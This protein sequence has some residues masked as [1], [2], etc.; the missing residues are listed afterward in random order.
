MEKFGILTYHRADNLGAVLQAYALQ[1]ALSVCSAESQIIDYCC[2]KVDGTEVQCGGL[3]ALVYKGYH[4]WKHIGFARFR[5]QFLN[6]SE[7]YTKKTVS[8]CVENYDGF[9]TGSDQVWNYEC[10]GWDDTYFLPFVSDA[11]KYAYAASIGQYRFAVSEQEHVRK[12][13]TDFSAIS[14]REVSAQEHLHQ[15]GVENVHVCPDPVM[16]LGA[17]QWKRLMSPRRTKKKYVFVYMIMH[18]EEVLRRAKEYAYSHGYQV[19]CNKTSPEFILH[20][21]PEDFLSWIF[22]AECVFTNS[23]HGTAFSLIFEKPF[24][25]QTLCSDGRIN[26]RVAEILKCVSVQ[27]CAMEKAAE[28]LKPEARSALE[29][30]QQKGYRYLDEICN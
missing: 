22:Y 25:A 6:L 11:K 19:I 21:S 8:K 5:K 20:G 26:G 2:E 15:F 9:I 29:L 13:L 10:S 16:L 4:F 14:V 1:T 24:L 23:F 30:L 17:Q 3:K 27:Q 18:S 12:L 7:E 28:P